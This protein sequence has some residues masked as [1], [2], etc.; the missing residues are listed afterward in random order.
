MRTRLWP[1]TVTS[2]QTV[3]TFDVLRQFEKLNKFGHITATDYYRAL[4]HMTDATGLSNLPVHRYASISS[5]TTYSNKQDRARQFMIMTRE[6]AHLKMVKRSGIHLRGG[7]STCADG[8]LAVRCRTC[9]IDGVNLP[10]GW[11]T[12][13][14]QYVSA[15]VACEYGLTSISR[16]LYRLHVAQDANMKLNN[17]VHRCGAADKPLQPGSAYMVD[18]APLHDYLKDFIDQK[19]VFFPIVFYRMR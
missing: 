14:K 6:W 3:A 13:Q 16:W 1:A 5:H 15:N 9:P 12:S 17:R 7:L 8:E 18:P 4:V 19:E 10:N 11:E 2:P